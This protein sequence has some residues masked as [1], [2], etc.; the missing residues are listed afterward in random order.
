MRN[1]PWRREEV[2]LALDIYRK[3]GGRDIGID[4]PDV[5]ETSALLRGMAKQ[6]G[7][8]TYRN[9]SGVKMKMMNFRSLDPSYTADGRT[10]LTGASSTDRK[11]W[12]EFEENPQQLA[13]TAQSIR[14][15]ALSK[16]SDEDAEEVQSY[17]AKE[18]KVS[19]RLHR[20]HE[21]NPA[22]VAARKRQALQAKGDLN[23]E[24]CGFSFAAVYGGRGEGFIEAHHTNPVHSM[25][26][27]DE[28]TLDDLVLLCSNC[29]RMVH[30][31]K[32]WLSLDELRALLV[33]H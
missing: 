6:E 3:H 7:L 31:S 4:H 20:R 8:E 12:S 30:Q 1:P 32:P 18:G 28:T 27:G 33:T 26:E 16:M 13:L 15:G 21:R 14:D 23:C 11:V 22:I 25:Q 10:G 19:Y 24:A 5:V 9:A 29:H 17:S 2:I